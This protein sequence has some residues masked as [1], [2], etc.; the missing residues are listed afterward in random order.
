MKKCPTCSQTYDDRYLVCPSDNTQLIVDTGDPMLGRLLDNRYRLTCKIGEGGMG[1]IY[2]ATHTEMGRTC[3]IKLL[4]PITSGRDE[5]LARFKREAKMA[6]RIDNPHAVTIYDFGE[7]E[8]GLL[9]L[10]MEFIDGRPLSKL[11]ADLRMLPIDRVAHITDQIAEALN[12]AHALGIVHRD[13]KPDN[14]MIT[15][16]GGDADYVKVLDFGIAKTVA[17]DSADHLTKTGFVLGTPVYMSPEQ[18]LGE[19]LDGR[20]DIYSLAIIVYEMLSGKLP[21]VGDNQQAVMMKRITG[22]P[23]PLRSIAPQVGEG[24]ERV[25]MQGLAREPDERVADVLAFADALS[26]AMHGGTGL[27]GKGTTRR[28][29][30]Q[31]TDGKTMM[32]AAGNP[33]EPD[34]AK[35]AAGHDATL[36]IDVNSTAQSGPGTKPMTQS[37][38]SYQ[39]RPQTANTPPLPERDPFDLPPAS[40]ASSLPPPLGLTEPFNPPATQST[41][42]VATVETPRR[43]PVAMIAVIAVLI[44]L[45]GVAVFLFLPRG[46]SG[47]TLTFKN[48]PPGA[49]VFIN[50][51]S[52]GTVG[53]D[54]TLKVADITPGQA[55]IKLTK[56]GFLDFTRSVTGNKG[57]EQA[58][59]AL[60][61]PLEIDYN[62]GKM[63][64]IP[65]GEFLM[66]SDTGPTDERPAHKVKLP[67]YY[68]DKYEVT[69]EQYKRFCDAERGGKYPVTAIDPNYVTQFPKL[70]VVGITYD[71]A[72]EFAKWAGKR[73]P[74]EAEWEKAAS[75]D[76]RTGKKRTYPWGDDKNAGSANI[77][78]DKDPHMSP[79]GTNA[80][81]VSPYGVFDMGGNAGEWIDGIFSPYDGNAAPNADYGKTRIIRGASMH[82]PLE[83]ARTTF[84]GSIGFEIP[85]EKL[86]TMLVGIRCA[87]SADDPK[88]QD[89]L[90]A[91]S[92]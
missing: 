12:A 61:L 38:E 1:A 10:A 21:F 44:V 31:A 64:L 63:V 75:W 46:G 62:N 89:H 77:G 81:D 57:D 85:K 52:R 20:S 18:L 35:P 68:I 54:G 33:T 41:P 28:I 23:V 32:W 15:R 45:A 80:G 29:N 48:A 42:S 19:K 72:I 82:S 13:L 69:N 70:P 78:R 90:R 22:A 36:V 11:I 6:S 3:A 34:A 17:D 40:L 60:M 26:N 47:L 71:D 58:I 39:T 51:A 50:D 8:S 86:P 73:L 7:A 76:A 30:D 9:F 67:A 59:E 2:Q 49:Q 84:R 65:E 79:G 56:D 16:K 14:V 27:L 66:G 37:P 5:A 53:A 91:R 92:K 25:V 55:M 43:R 4:A 24:V 87:I 83:E 74:N 88:I